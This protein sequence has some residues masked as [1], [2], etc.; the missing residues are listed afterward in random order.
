MFLS[1]MLSVPVWIR[2]SPLHCTSTG[3]DLNGYTLESDP[4]LVQIADMYL[5]GYMSSVNGRLP[6]PILVQKFLLT[7]THV[8]VENALSRFQIR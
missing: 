1:S 8:I 2:S 4:K 6:V 7:S 3:T 5:Y